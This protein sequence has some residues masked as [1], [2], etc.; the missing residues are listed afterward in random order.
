MTET[1]R[2]AALALLVVG[3]V[4]IPNGAWLFP[5]E[6]ETRYTYERTQLVVENG[7]L[8]P[9][10]EPL[11][12]YAE[13]HHLRGVDC[14]RVLAPRDCTLDRY[15]LSQGP[16]TV[17]GEADRVGQPRYT[18]IRGDYYRRVVAVNGSRTKL[19]VRA[20]DPETVR[21]ELATRARPV[22][23][24]AV[25]ESQPVYRAV[26]TGEPATSF[27]A[28]HEASL[29]QVYV[30]NGSHYTA[31][32]TAESELDRPLIAPATRSGISYAGAVVA[33]VFAP[34][35]FVSGSDRGPL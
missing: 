8:T 21:A 4:A 24:S 6:G 28:P 29:G 1:R 20:V 19:D 18:R 15:L 34:L 32:V 5:N 16:L 12:E 3:L 33:S 10:A 2:Y 30:Q 11:D 27:V 35:L 26:A 25:R 22:Q 14:D 13:F 7:T 23:P 9:R 17:D 31:I